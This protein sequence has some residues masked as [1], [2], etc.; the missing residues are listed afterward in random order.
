[1]GRSLIKALTPNRDGNGRDTM[2]PNNMRRISRR[3]T[4]HQRKAGNKNQTLKTALA[5]ERQH[6]H[7]RQQKR[8]DDEHSIGASLRLSALLT[9]H[10]ETDRGSLSTPSTAEMSCVNSPTSQVEK[11]HNKFEFVFDPDVSHDLG[12]SFGAKDSSDRNRNIHN[13]RY[14]RYSLKTDDA[15]AAS[16][17]AVERL[18]D[19]PE[20]H[21]K[22]DPET[23]NVKENHNQYL[24]RRYNRQR[25]ERGLDFL[26]PPG[27]D[28]D[29]SIGGAIWKGKDKNNIMTKKRP[30]TKESR[31]SVEKSFEGFSLNPAVNLDGSNAVIQSKSDQASERNKFDDEPSKTIDQPFTNIVATKIRPLFEKI[32]TSIHV[33]LNNDGDESVLSGNESYQSHRSEEGTNMTSLEQVH[34]SHQPRIKS[35]FDIVKPSSTYDT[36][37]SPTGVDDFDEISSELYL[38][39]DVNLE[40]NK[41]SSNPQPSTLSPIHTQ[42][43]Q[44]PMKK[45]NM[46]VHYNTNEAIIHLKSRLN[47]LTATTPCRVPMSYNSVASPGSYS[48]ANILKIKSRLRRIES[49]YKQ[50]RTCVVQNA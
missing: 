3:T 31:R 36:N 41:K 25:I 26:C 35:G 46:P 21:N 45:S 28:D 37:C 38:H 43:S 8:Q 11:S 27:S 17:L 40:T 24:A 44:F 13:R 47:D 10:H 12:I 6:Q 2:R 4:Q 33:T 22:D 48:S 20:Q 42:D 5:R 23:K 34:L 15:D 18:R 7:Q 49:E 14:S 39:K 32:P 29:V 19:L 9:S 1:M 30:M 16:D 50:I